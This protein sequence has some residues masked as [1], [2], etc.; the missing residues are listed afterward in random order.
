MGIRF[1]QQEIIQCYGLKY[2]RMAMI[3]QS[4]KVGKAFST[5]KIALMLSDPFKCAESI[6]LH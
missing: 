2:F 5:L 6:V 3:F 4:S 1:V